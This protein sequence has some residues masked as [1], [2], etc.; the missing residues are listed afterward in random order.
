MVVQTHKKNVTHKLE[1]L[2]D[3]KYLLRET[4]HTLLTTDFPF[5]LFVSVTEY[6]LTVLT[7]TSQNLYFQLEKW[8]LFRSVAQLTTRIRQ[9]YF[10]VQGSVELFHNLL[11]YFWY[12]LHF[13][14]FKTK[15]LI[16]FYFLVEKPVTV[17]EL[18]HLIRWS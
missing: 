1:R 7:V 11:V 18:E 15:L 2:V 12:F 5:V 10:I 14:L 3:M 8:H 6:R 13:S 17:A 9:T 4:S 16:P